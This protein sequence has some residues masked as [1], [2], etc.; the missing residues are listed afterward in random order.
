MGSL[1]LLGV[2]E[3][4]YE[5]IKAALLRAEAPERVIRAPQPHH[6]GLYMMD[7]VLV[8]EHDADAG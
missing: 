8:K 3:S 2:S 1:L 4:A 6:E 5:E 7:L